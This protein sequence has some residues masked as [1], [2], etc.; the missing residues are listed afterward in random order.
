MPL[1]TEA[2][3]PPIAPI[4]KPIA[5]KIPANLAISNAGLGGT[6][7]AAAG[8]LLTPSCTALTIFSCTVFA[9][10]AANFCTCSLTILDSFL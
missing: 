4:A 8:G 1:T 6:L 2:R 9:L 5:A 3:I 10:D 7:G